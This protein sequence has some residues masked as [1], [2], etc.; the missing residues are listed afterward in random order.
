MFR[1]KKNNQRKALIQAQNTMHTNGG[2][3]KKTNNV[4]TQKRLKY[5][6]QIPANTQKVTKGKNRIAQLIHVT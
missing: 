2:Q 4:S 5:N 6:E 1:K 3:K